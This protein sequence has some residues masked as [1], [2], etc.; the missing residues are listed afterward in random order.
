MH[1]NSLST[2]PPPTISISGSST[3]YNGTTFTLTGAIELHLSVDTD[4]LVTGTWSHRSRLLETTSPPYPSNLTFQP[5]ATNSSG[6]YSLF[7][8]VRAADG[9]MFIVESIV[10]ATYDLIVQ[11]KL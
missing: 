4:V 6:E 3:P 10:N 7:V 11:R 5:L 9:S 2:V 8:Q 1:N